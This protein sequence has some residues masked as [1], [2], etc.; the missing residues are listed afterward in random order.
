MGTHDV[1][2]ATLIHIAI[3]ADQ[4]VVTNIGPAQGVHVVGLDVLQLGD[5]GGLGGAVVTGGVV[6]H[7]VAQGAS[8]GALAFGRATAPLRLGDD[9]QAEGGLGAEEHSEKDDD[10]VSHVCGSV[11]VCVLC[12]DSA[13]YTRSPGLSLQ[14]DAKR[15]GRV[16]SYDMGGYLGKILIWR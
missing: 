13:F 4:E 15:S 9:G 2:A 11:V 10:F 3:T 16:L 8:Q 7:S 5:A 12:S 14:G 6:D 1:P